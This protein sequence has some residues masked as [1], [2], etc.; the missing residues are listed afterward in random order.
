MRSAIAPSDASADAC[1]PTRRTLRWRL[2]MI[3]PAIGRATSEQHDTGHEDRPAEHD[4]GDAVSAMPTPISNGQ[5]LAWGRNWSSS[6]GLDSAVGAA[7]RGALEA[8]LEARGSRPRW[9]RSTPVRTSSTVPAASP[10]NTP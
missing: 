8:V 3:Q 2:W 7:R 4:A 9:R 1:R 10:D 6:T 5:M